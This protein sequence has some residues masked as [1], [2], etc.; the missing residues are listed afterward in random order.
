MNDVLTIGKKVSDSV[1]ST[2]I[3]GN[4]E[5]VG[6]Q[7][8]NTTNIQVV[9]YSNG[10]Y[11]GVNF[12]VTGSGSGAVGI[13]T[14]AAGIVTGEPAITTVG[15]GYVVGDLLV[16]LHQMLVEDV[17]QRFLLRL[18]VVETLCI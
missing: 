7:V 5:Q 15:E 6:G 1:D 18:S 13:V 12:H 9:R 14:V 17:E 11:T 8:T 16:L 2:A 10:T 3:S 4:I